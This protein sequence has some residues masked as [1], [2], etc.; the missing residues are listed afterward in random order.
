MGA[1]LEKRRFVPSWA[2][3]H[4][5]GLVG[6]SRT[7]RCVYYETLADALLYL[8]HEIV[9]CIWPDIPKT[10]GEEWRDGLIDYELAWLEKLCQTPNERRCL[11][12]WRAYAEEDSDGTTYEEEARMVTHLFRLPDPWA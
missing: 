9:H 3:I 7:S 12:A 1:R 5:N 10:P 6:F 2:E 8:P 11:E 4:P